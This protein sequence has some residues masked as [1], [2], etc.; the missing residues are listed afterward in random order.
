MPVIP[1]YS[2]YK[3]GCMDFNEKHDYIFMDV[4][5]FHNNNHSNL[6]ARLC[7]HASHQWVQWA[8]I[9]PFYPFSTNETI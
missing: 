4:R 2:I 6:S 9:K 5:V 3:K 7:C 1:D 8:F